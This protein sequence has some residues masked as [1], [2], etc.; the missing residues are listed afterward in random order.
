MPGKV[1]QVEDE[2]GEGRVLVEF[3]WMEGNTQCYPAAM[4]SLMSGAGCGTWFPP[5]VGDEVLV[6]FDQ[7]LITQPYIVGFLWNGEQRPP[8]TDIQTRMIQS[9]NG[10]QIVIYDPTP[11]SGDQGYIRLQD[12]HGNIIELANG[13]IIIHSPGAI[14]LDSPQV[15]ING[16]PVGP[17]PRPI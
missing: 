3:P 17:A 14:V 8:T 1:K 13:S 12:A 15:V 9:V 2:A 10:H 6:A 11:E 4:A 5:Q 16:R 7:G